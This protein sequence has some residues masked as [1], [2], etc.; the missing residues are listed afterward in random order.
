MLCTS[1]FK[2]TLLSKT[3]KPNPNTSIEEEVFGA[4]DNPSPLLQIVEQEIAM[5]VS[6]NV[7]IVIDRYK[8][9]SALRSVLK[10][11][12]SVHLYMISRSILIYMNK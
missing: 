9:I 5:N 6:G 11:T 3:Y 10:V 2:E 12:D 4:T 1:S 7:S 8:D